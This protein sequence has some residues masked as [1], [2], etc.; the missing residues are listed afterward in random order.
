MLELALHVLD[1]LR[2]AVEAGATQVELTIVEDEPA[3]RLALTVTDNGRGMDDETIRRA[4]NPFYTTRRT[5]HVGL[6]LPLLV[7]AAE[8]AGGGLTIRSR[9]G[10]GTTV[11]TTFRLSHPDRQPLGDM[12]A[13]LLAFLLADTAPDLRYTHRLNRQGGAVPPAER[14]FAFDAAAVRAE[15]DG[16]PLNHP[17]VAR[18]LAEYLA[19]GERE[20][21]E[22]AHYEPG[23]V[24]GAGV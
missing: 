9:A 20:L 6:G 16:L 13:T 7:A 24:E 5:R 2:N 1:I 4:L 21:Y 14:E 15:L 17:I 11:E 19:E 12:A 8:T 22:M 10:E 18:W 23:A 3:D